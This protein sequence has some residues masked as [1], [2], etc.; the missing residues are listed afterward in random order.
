MLMKAR[1]NTPFRYDYVG[2][3]LRPAEIKKARADYQEG[4]I[5]AKALKEIENKHIDTL[6]QKQKEAGYH[7]ITDGEYRRAYWH[8][9]FM[10]GFNGVKH[11]EL[12]HGYFFHG[13]ETTKGSIAI[14]GKISGEHHP[15]V[16]DYKFVKQF[17]DDQVIAKQTIPAPAQ[18]LAELYRGDNTKNTKK[19]YPDE[20]V[21]IADIAHAYHTVLLDLYKAGCRNV[22]LDDC[23]WG[24]IVDDRY[25]NAKM[26][27][28]VSIDDE[29]NKYLK[30][31]TLALE[32]LP[33]DLIVNT[34]ICRGNYHSTYACSGAY[35]RVAPYVFAKENVQAFYLE[36]DDERSG[37]FE[38]LKYVPEGKKVVLGLVTTK[39]S[40]LERKEHIIARIKEAS[41][42]VPLENLYLSPQCGFASCEI[43]NKLTDHDQWAKL[44]LVKE[45]AE[46]VWA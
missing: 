31:N 39:K 6:I 2:S 25:W 7:V 17:E 35:D 38:A 22:Q 42:Y 20:D 30:I 19:Y 41:Q 36:F 33:E 15:F 32:D 37:S 44:A 5:D 18:M 8:L 27:E 16:E 46:E 43:G 12:E 28:G 45:I 10:W 29:A 14:T 4:K 34:H 26:G 1:T 9:D 24:M 3:F 40:L 21:L 23:T 11:I 13:E